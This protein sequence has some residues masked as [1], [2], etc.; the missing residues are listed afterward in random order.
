MPLE[1]GDGAGVGVAHR[2]EHDEGDGRGVEHGLEAALRFVQRGLGAG[3][4]HEDGGL[5][6]ADVR[7]RALAG[8]RGARRVEVDGERA[9]HLAVLPHHRRGVDG[10]EALLARQRPQARVGA[11]VLG[12]GDDGALAARAGQRAP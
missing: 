2:R 10:A 9:D 7:Q 12:V 6:G 4:A 11:G 8:G 1:V 5:A 3:A